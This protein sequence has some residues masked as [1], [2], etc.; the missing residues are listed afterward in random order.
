MN[1]RL[2]FCFKRLESILANRIMCKILLGPLFRNNRESQVV[3]AICR[4][5][6]REEHDTKTIHHI[7]L[8]SFARSSG[9]D[10]N[11]CHVVYARL[12]YVNE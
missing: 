5:S 6:E 7:A 12:P 4:H 11:E 1:T 3:F 10:V 9:M 2:T 8:P